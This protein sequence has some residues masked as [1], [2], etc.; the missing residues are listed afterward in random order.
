MTQYSNNEVRFLWCNLILVIRIIA[1]TAIPI[2][3]YKALFSVRILILPVNYLTHFVKSF[4]F[5][6]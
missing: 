4:I 1:V 3:A 5:G 2:V 6:V